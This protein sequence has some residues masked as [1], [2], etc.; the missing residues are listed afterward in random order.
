MN[1]IVPAETAARAFQQAHLMRRIAAPEP[2][3]SIAA[4]ARELDRD[5]ANTRKTLKTLERDGLVAPSA[6]GHELTSI[7]VRAL[8][9]LDVAEGASDVAGGILQL[10]HAAIRPNPLNPRTNFDEDGLAEL[11]ESIA[12]VDQVIVPLIVFPAGADG[13]HTL[14]AGERRWRAVRALIDDGRWA[15]DRPL[16]CIERE[17]DSA[18]AAL[19]GLVENG[20]REDLNLYD[21]AQAYV[22]LMEATGWSARE[23]AKR[24]GKSAR[25]VQEA[26]QVVRDAN[27][28]QVEEFRRGVIRWEDL[29]NGV[30]KLSE[31]PLYQLVASELPE[32][33]AEL[34]RRTSEGMRLMAVEDA[35]SRAAAAPAAQVD[36]E[37]LAP[38]RIDLTPQ[39]TLILVEIEAATRARP[40]A[41]AP[42][43]PTVQLKS[44]LDVG[45][46]VHT[47]VARLASEGLIAVTGSWPT[48]VALLTAGRQWLSSAAGAFMEPTWKLRA[49]RM[50]VGLD[51][52][53]CDT[54]E[55]EDEYATAWLNIEKPPKPPALTDV[56]AL[57]LLELADHNARNEDKAQAYYGAPIRS[58]FDRPE[59]AA[60]VERRLARGSD[61]Y[62]WQ[63]GFWRLRL[64][65][66]GQRALE[67]RDIYLGNAG[68][69]TAALQKLR[70][71]LDVKPE[72]GATY[73]TDWLNNPIRPDPA[74]AEEQGRKKAA[75]DRAEQTRDELATAK[76][77]IATKFAELKR[78]V[79]SLDGETAG[80][81]IAEFMRDTLQAHAPWRF[82]ENDHRAPVRSANGAGIGLGSYSPIS[83]ELAAMC[84]NLVAG[85]PPAEWP[86]ET[87]EVLSRIEYEAAIVDSV[88][89]AIAE[90]E[91]DVSLTRERAA[92]LAKAKLDSVLAERSID[93]GDDSCGWDSDAADEQASEILTELEQG[94]EG[95]A[96]Q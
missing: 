29:R 84:V 95:A 24:T 25:A 78:Q 30:R 65:D 91:P 2:I 41:K 15:A 54:L 18:Q 14:A 88:M 48:C 12:G 52:P 64:N 38:R 94:A 89:T 36:L 9:A 44:N 74:W 59:V 58:D 33:Q 75:A 49:A 73:V 32:D 56:E 82:V 70:R 86:L 31:K 46:K 42:L 83:T 6:T 96:E 10:Q 87:G 57:T 28:E 8:Q 37:D 43:G 27:P 67:A 47:D 55:V 81:R 23:C 60:L 4:L 77:A 63:D 66:E 90:G 68:G 16:P 17:E 22:A 19:I 53:R 72:Q 51:E 93:Y 21:Q 13:V 45:A 26:V 5:E 20:Q 34:E 85:V 3:E 11:A 92:E 80:A 61:R 62:D 1:A 76:A 35:Q 71:N 40:A 7:G 50:A 69:R 79:R 39:Q